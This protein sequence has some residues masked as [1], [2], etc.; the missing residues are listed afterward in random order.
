MRTTSLPSWRYKSGLYALRASPASGI[1][2]L[3]ATGNGVDDIVTVAPQSPPLI[4]RQVW[5]IEPVHGK[6]GAYTITIHTFG[7]H[8]FPKDGEPIP[9]RPVFTSE[10]SYEWYIAYK[11][12]PGV[13]HTITIQAHT[14]LIGVGLYAGT[15]DKEQVVIIPVPV[16]PDAEAPYWQ[17][18]PHLVS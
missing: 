8:W 13:P 6:K 10:K 7:G 16:I 1:G 9:E 17:F 4:E 15:N 18:K 2:G 5:K 11:E 14:K 3:Y 12:I